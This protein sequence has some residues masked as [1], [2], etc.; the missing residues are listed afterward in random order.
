MLNRILDEMDMDDEERQVV[1]YGLRKFLMFMIS[2]LVVA[3]IGVLTNEIY[4]LVVFLLLFIPL[5]IFAGGMHLPSIKLCALFSATLIYGIAL[6]S[7][8]IQYVMLNQ[9]MI[10]IVCIVAAI[11]IICLAPVDTINKALYDREKRRFKC[12]S[13]IIV[14]VELFLL[15]SLKSFDTIEFMLCIVFVLESIFLIIQAIVN[16]FR[17]IRRLENND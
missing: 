11:I 7:K 17:K 9:K 15:V 14:F 10:F 6:V 5:R 2:L 8:H 3:I 12:I 4:N 16:Y 1:G 13:G